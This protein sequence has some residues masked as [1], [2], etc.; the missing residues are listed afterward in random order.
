[1]DPQTNPIIPGN[2]Q[3]PPPMPAN[4]E[5]PRIE[6][7]TISLPPSESKSSGPIIGIIVVILLL[8]GGAL[9]VWKT[10]LADQFIPTPLPTTDAATS[11]FETVGTSTEPSDIETDLINTDL[12]DLDL[13]L[14]ALLIESTR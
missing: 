10:K 8:V 11:A 9:Y 7:E 12:D 6:P 1:M 14:G 5:T 13:D 3:T 4:K 2:T